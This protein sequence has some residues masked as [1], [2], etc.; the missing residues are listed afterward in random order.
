MKKPEFLSL[1][2]TPWALSLS[3]HLFF[4]GAVVLMT[5][6][7]M[8]TL[9]LVSLDLAPL[10]ASSAAP[11]EDMDQWHKPL[12]RHHLMP[13]PKPQPTA[14]PSAGD[15]GPVRSVAQVGQMPR[16][17][18]VVKPVYP[19]VA[20]KANVE[21]VVILQVEIDASGTVMAAQVVK[22]LGSGCDEAAL[23]AVKQ[24]AF[25]PAYEDGKPVPVRI[26]VPYRFKI[27]E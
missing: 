13:I 4:V 7:R 5:W 1:E 21:G 9:P 24:T 18:M 20:K 25:V 22:S 3:V 14:P 19:E 6:S 10:T 23:E 16:M 15:Q 17:K 2:L 11:A 12:S 26:R 8:V 27:G